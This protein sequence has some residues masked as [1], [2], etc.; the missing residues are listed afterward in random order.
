MWLGVNAHLALFWE[1]ISG[2]DFAAAVIPQSILLRKDV[3]AGLH[4]V[5]I[6]VDCFLLRNGTISRL[7]LAGVIAPSNL[8]REAMRA[9]R[10]RLCVVAAMLMRK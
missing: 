10:D 8:P 3:I 4:S 7:R 6:I 1:S 9:L 2:P 5:A